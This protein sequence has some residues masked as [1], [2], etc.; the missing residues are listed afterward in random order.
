M[1]T[2]FNK[3]MIPILL[4][5]AL[6][7]HGNSCLEEIHD[8]RKTVEENTEMF[9]A[10]KETVNNQE[11]RIQR[12]ET[13]LA[14]SEDEKLILA[15]RLEILENLTFKSEQDPEVELSTQEIRPPECNEKVHSQEREN[16]DLRTRLAKSE[17][18]ILDMKRRTE[19]LENLN[20]KP[21]ILKFPEEIILSKEA[22]S[23]QDN[24]TT[25]VK[26][27][28]A[29]QAQLE[30]ESVSQRVSPGVGA[31]YAY[32]SHDEPNPGPHH[33][34]IFDVPV[35][36][37]GNGYNHFSGTFSVPSSGVYVFSWTIHCSD[38]GYIYSQLVANDDV[39][40]AILTNSE[41]TIDWISTT[42]LVVK[43]VNHGDV[44][45]VRTD[46]VHGPVGDIK[47]S[48]THYRTSFS[49]WKLQ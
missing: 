19:K 5:Y 15:R 28:Q 22:S 31:F 30:H 39:L 2:M 41:S 17:D 27:R 23:F 14:K 12:L 24:G 3:C 26:E 36:N 34:L 37:L 43:E 32:M 9:R 4:I 44:V 35:T 29:Q 46:P 10:F 8:L 16:Q 33:T 21:E 18:E 1:F 6:H 20:S 7:I 47:S 42:G 45:Y 25:Y 49:G 48:S 11:R 13:R 40:G 38:R